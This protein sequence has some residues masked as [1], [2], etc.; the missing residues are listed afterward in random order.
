[1]LQVINNLGPIF[2]ILLLGAVLARYGWLTEGFTKPL[3]R[4]IYWIALP[5]V[6]LVSLATARFDVGS[7]L[8]VFLVFMGGTAGSVALSALI[9]LPLRLP[10]PSGA[11]FVQ[12]AFRGNL[13][14]I[15][16]PVLTYKVASSHLPAAE[17]QSLLATC[18]L[19]L[20]ASMIVY[21]ILSIIVLIPCQRLLAARA[22]HD[23]APVPEPPHML[24]QIATNPLIIASLGGALLGGF[25]VPLPEVLIGTLKSLGNM[26]VPGALLCIGAGLGTTKL[27]GQLLVPSLSAIVK[28]AATPVLTLFVA[29]HADLQG[30]QL[31]LAMIFAA[32]PTAAAS[33]ILA[34]RMG[35]DAPLAG[36]AIALSTLYSVISL[37][38]VLTLFG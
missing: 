21:N 17:A 14:L 28:V 2:L 7:A 1:M 34:D 4:L 36:S 11:S 5:S 32:S 25:A 38:I 29:A 16:L 22:G 6:V 3:N 20:G 15:G 33:Y 12:A 19:V 35:G 30:L 24:Q 37:F 31:L 26:A 23:D 13:A 10:T 8:K 27:R 9:S 18:A